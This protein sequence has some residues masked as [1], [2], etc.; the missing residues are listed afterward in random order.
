MIRPKIT[1]DI[2]REKLGGLLNGAPTV[3]QCIR[4]ISFAISLIICYVNCILFGLS[5]SQFIIGFNAFIH[6]T[7]AVSATIS[8]QYASESS[9]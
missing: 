6:P 8:K 3:T 2:F 9:F 4:A 5:I 7:M 1:A